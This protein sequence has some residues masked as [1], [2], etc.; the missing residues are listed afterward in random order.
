MLIYALL[1]AYV[2]VVGCHSKSESFVS[3]NFSLRGARRQVYLMCT[4][5]CQ[6]CMSAQQLQ[7]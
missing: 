4:C 5:V 3:H 1:F 7:R 6:L 2:A